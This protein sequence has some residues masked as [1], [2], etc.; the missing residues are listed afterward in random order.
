MY[1]MRR[2]LSFILVI[3]GFLVCTNVSAQDTIV[4]P[5]PI[6]A[7]VN[8]AGG[9]NTCNG[10]GGVQVEYFVGKQVSLIGA[11]GI[12]SWGLKMGAGARMYM[13]DH[14][15][16]ALAVSY[17]TASGLQQLKL[18]DVAVINAQGIPEVRSVDL[19]LFRL[20]TI[21]IS[22]LE[23]FPMGKKHNRF[24]LEA[25]YS[26]A[27]QGKKDSNYRILEPLILDESTKQALRLLQPGG[28]MLSMG[29]SFPF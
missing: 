15:G 24:F 21:N 1:C 26:I 22:V 4:L 12:G 27:L 11:G 25:G 5:H 23:M 7:Y 28:L 2:I 20:H 13:Y 8:F 14:A 10:L 18:Q 3:I 9:I 17:A 19:E 16:P 29:F 6:K